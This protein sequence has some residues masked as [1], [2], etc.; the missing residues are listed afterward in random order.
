M[1][2]VDQSS[3][4][5]TVA[6]GKDCWG[7]ELVAVEQAAKAVRIAMGAIATDWLSAI[8]LNQL[9]GRLVIWFTSFPVYCLSYVYA[10]M[11][12][13]KGISLYRHLIP[14]PGWLVIRQTRYLV[15]L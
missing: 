6:V 1:A 5:T 14:D 13:A 2:L 9:S 11:R 7:V 12:D 4:E 15:I 3:M 10:L 8:K